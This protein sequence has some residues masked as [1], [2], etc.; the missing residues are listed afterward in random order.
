MNH[1][2][3]KRVVKDQMGNTVVLLFG[4]D[5]GGDRRSLTNSVSEILMEYGC[6]TIIYYDSEGSATKYSA[7]GGYLNPSDY[8]KN[9]L[10]NF[11]GAV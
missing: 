7:V 8:E 3:E 1:I 2:I 9:L 5:A 11:M 10:T 6:S 4:K